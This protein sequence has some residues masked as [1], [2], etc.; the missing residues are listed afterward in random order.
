MQAQLGLETSLAY[1]LFKNSDQLFIKYPRSFNN[2]SLVVDTYKDMNIIFTL[3]NISS[4][5]IFEKYVDENHITFKYLNYTFNIYH[6]N[7]LNST[8]YKYNN[9]EQDNHNGISFKL[10]PVEAAIA[11]CFQEYSRKHEIHFLMDA[12]VLISLYVSNFSKNILLSYLLQL[13]VNV[14]K[15]M[16]KAMSSIKLLDF[17]SLFAFE[18]PKEQYQESIHATIGFCYSG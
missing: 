13:G 3:L 17:D 7:H 11:Y 14:K 15:L 5:S 6:I 10:L 12:C 16:K 1:Y 18:I 8:L 2:P 4:S 9:A